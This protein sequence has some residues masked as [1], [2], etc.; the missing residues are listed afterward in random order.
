MPEVPSVRGAGFLGVW[1]RLTA[2]VEEGRLSRAELEARL[3]AQDL[4]ILDAKPEPSLWYPIAS[5]G[6]LA[7]ILVDVEG[8]GCL[9]Y[10]KVQGRQT[11]ESLLTRSSVKSVV[12][13]AL[14]REDRAGSFLL[15]V[16]SLI[17]NFGRWSFEGD[18]HDFKVEVSEAESFP[19]LSPWA[20]SGF[21]EVIFQ[22]VAGGRFEVTFTRPD[23]DRVIFRGRQL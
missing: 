12:D 4:E 7:Q 10:Q 3:E 14:K 17:Y 21:A 11:A 5:V 16:A 6:R 23:R 22:R 19:D 1:E 9:E 18:L 20:V 8:A 2:L 13:A 15:G